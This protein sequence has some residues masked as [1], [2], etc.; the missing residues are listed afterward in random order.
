MR[1]TERQQPNLNPNSNSNP[2]PKTC[3]QVARQ[4][5]E[6]HG[7]TGPSLKALVRVLGTKFEAS[8]DLARLHPSELPLPGQGLAPSEALQLA[9]RLARSGDAAQALRVL[10]LGLGGGYQPL[11]PQ[12]PPP[13]PL[14]P[15][16]LH[17]FDARNAL[18]PS[19]TL[20]SSDPHANLGGSLR[21]SAYGEHV[22][23]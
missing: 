3:W 12:P 18:P 10:G 5:G 8:V 2:K 21:S 9:S 13:R 4:F 15:G 14:R 19:H 16:L 23:M 7:L 17:Q 1:T 6:F 22:P 20:P 11:V